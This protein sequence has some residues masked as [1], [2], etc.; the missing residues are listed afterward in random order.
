MIGNKNYKTVKDLEEKNR[1]L[2]EQK[3]NREQS[4]LTKRTINIMKEIKL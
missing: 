4:Q 1:K 3:R 2:R